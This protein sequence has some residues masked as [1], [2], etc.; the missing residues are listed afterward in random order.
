[1]QQKAEGSKRGPPSTG[2][3]AIRC[4]I[5]TRMHPWTI[6]DALEL[7]NVAGWSSGYFDINE[8]GHVI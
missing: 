2:S 4:A 3:T 8:D 6:R 1:M 7:Y 5:T